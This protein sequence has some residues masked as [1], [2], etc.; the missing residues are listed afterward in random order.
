MFN[1]DRLDLA[2]KRC[3]KTARTLSEETGV[4]AVTISRI[5]NGTSAPTDE[6]LESFSRAL[7]FPVAFFLQDEIDLV[8]TKAASFRSLTSMTARERDASLAAGSIAFEISD[9]V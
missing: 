8:D 3:R 7:G 6:Q 1:P 4:P 9:W 5:L 2:R